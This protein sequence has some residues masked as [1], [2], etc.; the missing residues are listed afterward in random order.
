MVTLW[1]GRDTGREI[2][3]D[4]SSAITTTPREEIERSLAEDLAACEKELQTANDDRSRKRCVCRQQF[5]E[6]SL[7]SI[8]SGF[9]PRGMS[10]S[11]LEPAPPTHPNGLRY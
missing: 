6:K 4:W 11:L 1:R 9:A 2:A 5:L 10:F 3:F 7:A 8:R